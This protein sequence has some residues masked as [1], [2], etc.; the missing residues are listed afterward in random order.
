MTVAAGGRRLRLVHAV[1]VAAGGRRLRLVH[2]GRASTA[3]PGFALA[4]TSAPYWRLSAVR[5]AK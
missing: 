3:L 2:A 5:L 4:V 1:T